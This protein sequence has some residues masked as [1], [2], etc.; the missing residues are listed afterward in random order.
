MH[1]LLDGYNFL[2]RRYQEERPLSSLRENMLEDLLQMLSPPSER[3]PPLIDL[4]IIFDSTLPCD[5]SLIDRHLLHYLEV[6]F[7]SNGESADQHI[8]ALVQRSPH[9]AHYTVITSDKTLSNAARFHGAQT[10][11]ISEFTRLM[12]RQRLRSKRSTGRPA[13]EDRVSS[14]QPL[15]P[16]SPLIAE[17]D[18]ERWL[19]IF[20]ERYRREIT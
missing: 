9:P 5:G 18:H 14:H 8:L 11:S 4:S 2:F 19:R 20:E 12:D 16:Q 17:S 7:T 13:K 3:A 15:P 1:Y 10:L 6:I